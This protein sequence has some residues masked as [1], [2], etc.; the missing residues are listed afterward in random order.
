MDTNRRN[1]LAGA[2]LTAASLSRL[3]RAD[4]AADRPKVR[5]ITAFLKL[6]R[7]RYQEQVADTLRMLRQ[8]KRSLEAGGYQVETIRITTQ[9]FP[10]YVRDL[11][12]AETLRFFR[13]YDALA[14]KESFL[15]NIGPA[16]LSDRGDPADAALLGEILCATRSLR[17]SMV[18]ANDDGIQWK[19]LRAAAQLVKFVEEH[20]TGSA[21]NLNFA[22]TA[23]LAPYAPFF[24][25]SYHLGQ[26]RCFAIGTE[27]ANVVE[28]VFA[29]TTGNAPLAAER[30]SQVLAGHAVA[31]S[32]SPGKWRRGPDGRTWALTPHRR[33]Y[34]RYPSAPPSRS[35]RASPSEQAAP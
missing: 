14:I 28:R 33:P 9:P 24:P 15:G 2:L 5:T 16:M 4:D 29:Q 6:D 34:A 1:F 19:S 31:L 11:G 3:S 13:D 7:A 27:G 18:M 25:G 21:G 23:M 10:E 12:R 26:G 32:N 35:S 8:G 30:L 17:A 22:A 20:S